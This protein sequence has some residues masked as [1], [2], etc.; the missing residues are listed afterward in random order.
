MDQHPQKRHAV[1]QRGF[2][3]AGRSGQFENKAI[4][5]GMDTAFVPEI[6]SGLKRW[7]ISSLRRNVEK[8]PATAEH[9]Q[10]GS[11]IPE[12]FSEWNGGLEGR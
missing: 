3:C 7:N 10:S 5:A 4:S 11:A 12:C 8:P 9:T 2:D 6:A 1:R